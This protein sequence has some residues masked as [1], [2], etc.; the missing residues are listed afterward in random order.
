LEMEIRD[1]T[2]A[3][4]LQA[5]K[6]NHFPDG[7]ARITFEWLPANVSFGTILEMAGAT[8]LPP[9]I[10]RKATSDDK[11][12]YQT[13]YA[14]FEGSVAAPT[15][16]LHF[17]DALLE[18]IKAHHFSIE[19][20]TLHVGTGTFKPVSTPTIG[21]HDMHAEK[22]RITRSL[23]EQMISHLPGH[24]M[25]VGTTT[26]RSVESLYWLGN[27][28]FQQGFDAE[29]SHV[30]QWEPYDAKPLVTPRQALEN[31]LEYLDRNNREYLDFSTEIII[32]PGYSHKFA[33]SLITN[34]HLPQSTLLLL[35]ASFIGDSWKQAY[36]Y[37]MAHDFRFLSYGDGCLFFRESH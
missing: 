16:G 3:V 33:D 24:L 9:Y 36:E 15:A 35:I 11:Q 34:F 13:I 2:G 19:K 6:N 25:A 8:P 18:K 7:T 10:K 30:M 1:D 21:G 17:T 4:I 12:R 28:L 37:A 26:L 22:V 20:V 27:R 29:I 32:V 23:L 31:L 14:R 5:G